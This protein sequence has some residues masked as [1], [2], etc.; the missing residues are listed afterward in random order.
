MLVSDV[1][2]TNVVSIPGSTNMADARRIM[3]AHHFRRIPVINRGKLVGIVTKDILDKS[4]PS[5]LTTFSMHEISYLLNKITVEEVMRRDVVTVPPTM[6]VEEAVTLAQ[7]KHVGALVVTEG[8]K[9]VGMCTTNDFFYRI[10]NPVLGIGLP[11]SRIVVRNCHDGPDIEKVIS[12]INR[13]SIGITNLFVIDFPDVGK[14]DLVLHLNTSD[15]SRVIAE[16]IKLGFNTEDRPRT[17]IG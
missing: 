3:E 4:G 10:L 17:N 11:G 9:V 8:D 16:I 1:M 7:F 12:T 6:T 5:Q 13:L 15:D 2:S 14:H